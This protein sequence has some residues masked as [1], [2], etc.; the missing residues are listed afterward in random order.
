[1]GKILPQILSRL[2]LA[3][4][5]FFQRA[6]CLITCNHVHKLITPPLQVNRKSNYFVMVL[7]RIENLR[8]KLGLTKSEVYEKLEISQP[9]ISM[10]RAGQR[11][12]SIKTMR[13]LEAAEVAA[14]LKKPPPEEPSRPSR[15]SVESTSSPA[16]KVP[17]IGNLPAEKFQ[18]LELRLAALEHQT[19]EILKLLKGMK[20]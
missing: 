13:R 4:P 18:S 8:V 12:P 9:M 15:P 19:A 14:G 17:I 10:I 1:V 2:A 3:P 11:Q 6:F 7:D 16:E 20:R 5:S